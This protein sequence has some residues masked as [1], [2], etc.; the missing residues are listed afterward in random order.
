MADWQFVRQERGCAFWNDAVGDAISLTRVSTPMPSLSDRIGLQRLCRSVSASQR[1]GLI[2]VAVVEGAHG[3]CL[4]YVYKRLEV[5]A[6]KVFG[7]VDVPAATG[8]WNWMTVCLERGTTGVREAVVTARLLQ[9]G[10][11]TL[12]S[13]KASWA[14]DPYEPEYSG[15][16]SSTLRYISDAVEYDVA[17]PNHPLTKTRRELARLLAIQLPSPHGASMT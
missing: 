7:V 9:S 14:R 8:R 2:E 10:Q 4:T 3:P 13:Y 16:D 6:F 11:L 1:S 12:D 5:P 17:F 15:V